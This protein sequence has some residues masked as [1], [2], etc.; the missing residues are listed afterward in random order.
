MPI[1]LSSEFLQ[2][3]AGQASTFPTEE[4]R[5]PPLTQL[6]QE[7][8]VSVATLREQLEVARAMGLVDVRPRTGIRRLP[9]SF[10]PAVRQSLAYAISLDPACFSAYAELRNHIE[11]AYWDEA[12]R[13][14]TPEDH[15]M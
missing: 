14:L 3:L 2:Y 12:V 11:A 10:L 5:L 6:S 8:G 15:Q 9:F 1:Q 13:R 4:G 7:L